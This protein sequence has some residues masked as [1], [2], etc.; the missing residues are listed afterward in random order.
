LTQNDN[1]KWGFLNKKGKPQIAFEYEDVRSFRFGY[2]PVSQGK[3]K[4]GL[5]NR[6]NAKIV[7]CGFRSVQLN[8]A[9]TKFHIKDEND[10]IFIISENGECETNCPLFE[11]LR[12]AANKAN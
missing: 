11:K 1:G 12:A 9:E 10:T 3:G 7:P 8:E 6:F 4:W 2:A 5:I